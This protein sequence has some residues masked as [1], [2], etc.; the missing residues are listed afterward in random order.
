MNIELVQDDLS[1]RVS[2]LIRNGSE[3]VEL[4]Q[5]PTV[6]PFPSAESEYVFEEINE[7]W[8]ELPADDQNRIFLSYECIARSIENYD[9]TLAEL[10][11]FEVLLHAIYPYFTRILN[12]HDLVQMRKFLDDTYEDNV[13]NNLPETSENLLDYTRDDY[14]ELQALTLA[15]R[16]V[17][18]IFAVLR[19]LKG[20]TRME[21]EAAIVRILLADDADVM[22]SH[23]M[24]RLYGFI[25]AAIRRAET[26]PSCRPLLTDIIIKLLARIGTFT[27]SQPASYSLIHHI[28]TFIVHQVR[29]HAAMDVTDSFAAIS[30]PRS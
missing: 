15:F 23:A 30:T 17:L 18:P 26:L 9:A 11:S 16:S 5:G 13:P 3:Q 1:R 29:L 2:M 19:S 10:G 12:M 20:E 6:S 4:Q 22:K 7:Y 28:H 8:K 27:I 14:R 24:I 21:R 25:T